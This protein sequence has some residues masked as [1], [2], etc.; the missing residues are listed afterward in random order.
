MSMFFLLSFSKGWDS[1]WIT[2]WLRTSM[3]S[4]SASFSKM[5]VRWSSETRKRITVNTAPFILTISRMFYFLFTLH[6]L[7]H[8]RYIV[9]DCCEMLQHPT[10]ALTLWKKL[11]SQVVLVLV[12]KSLLVHLVVLRL[13]NWCSHICS[14]GK[15]TILN[16]L[17]QYDMTQDNT[18]GYDTTRYNRVRYNR[19]RYNT[20]RFNTI[21]YNTI[22]YDTITFFCCRAEIGCYI[23]FSVLFLVVRVKKKKKKKDKF[24]LAQLQTL[25]GGGVRAVVFSV[26]LWER[27]KSLH[28][29]RRKSGCADQIQSKTPNSGAKRMCS[30]YYYYCY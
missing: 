20:T 13:P 7:S 21:R 27:S 3:T 1:S 5:T 18:I 10:R 15:I 22:R 12:E 24:F 28:P 26:L 17:I 4:L 2:V 11:F 19:I 23:L 25:Q 8:V 9:A 29:R 6:F 30:S 16:S 14:C